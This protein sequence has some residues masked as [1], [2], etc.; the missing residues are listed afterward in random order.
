[1]LKQTY[2]LPLSSRKVTETAVKWFLKMKSA[3]ADHPERGKFEAWLMMHPNHASEYNAVADLWDDFDKKNALE[4]LANAVE[5]QQF[6]RKTESS[7]RR[8]KMAGQFMGMMFAGLLGYL[9]IDGYQQWQAQ[10]VMHLSQHTNPGEQLNQPLEDG[11]SLF[12][13]GD[14]DVEV[15][16]FR[17]K[18]Y[19]KLHL[20]EVIFEVNKDKESPLIVDRG[21]DKV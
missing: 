17:D 9:G 1:M 21:F 12:I 15:T 13:N 16:Y 14:S 20:G 18:R 8:R 6:V 3:D 5:Q 11:S 10:P 2:S 4:S 19:V 7:K